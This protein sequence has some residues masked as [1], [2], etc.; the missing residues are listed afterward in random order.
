MTP[1][2][3]A[4]KILIKADLSNGSNNEV[5]IKRLLDKEDYETLSVIKSVFDDE[6]KEMPKIYNSK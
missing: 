2:E 1:H 3:R 4:I 5:A 6:G